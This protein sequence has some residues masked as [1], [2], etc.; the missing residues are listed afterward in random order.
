MCVCVC[1]PC[2]LGSC[3]FPV[4]CG[5]SVKLCRCVSPWGHSH[6]RGA[7]PY[8]T[9]HFSQDPG[10]FYVTYWSHLWKVYRLTKGCCP[11]IGLA[12][13]ESFC[14]S[15]GW[16][17]L[18]FKQNYKKFIVSSRMIKNFGEDGFNKIRNCL[19]V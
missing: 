10:Q 13:W 18:P 14:F 6:A 1:V 15:E 4:P 16:F 5:K 19:C 3:S 17:H 9:L 2:L 11:Y 7:V 8:N 12:V